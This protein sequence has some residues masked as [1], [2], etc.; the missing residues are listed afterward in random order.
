MIA[1]DVR[2]KFLD[3]F[4]KNNHPIIPSSPLVPYG[5]P[6]LL[7]TSAG[8]VQFKPYYLGLKD[9]LKRATSCQK[10]FRTTDIDNVGKTIRHLTFFEM[11]GNFSFGDYFKEESLRWGYD[12]L[13]NEIGIDKNRLY[14]SFYK[15][16]IGPKDEEA[17]DIWKKILPKELHTHIFEMGEDNF[18]TMGDIG[19]CGP[20]SEIYYDRGEI[21]HKDCLGPW[22]GCDRYIE[23]WN[24]VFTQFDKQLDGSFKPLPKKNID[25]GMGLERISFIIEDKYSPFETSL[26]FPIIDR[27]IKENHNNFSSDYKKI[28][29][30][31]YSNYDS[32]EKYFT[33]LNDNKAFDIF[34]PTLRIVADHIRASSFLISEG[35]LP[36]NEGRGYILR[37]LIRRAERYVMLLGIK[38]VV[39]YKLVSSVNDIF[40]DIYPQISDNKQHIENV[41]RFEEEGFINTIENAERYINDLIISSKKS[42]LI[43]GSDAFKIYETYGYPY[44]LIKEIAN[45]NGIKVDDDEF[46]N[47]KLK[48]QDISR[49]WKGEE[50]YINIFHRINDRF[51]KTDF[52]GYDSFNSNSRL[53]AIVDEKGNIVN[54]AL[55]GIYWLV[56]DKTPFYAESGGQVSDK[57]LILDKD[58]IVA[59][60]LDVQKPLGDVFYHKVNLRSLIKT[61]LYYDLKID[62][63]RR[64][65]ISANHTATHLINAALKTVFGPNT[66][67]AGSLVSD[68]KFR[69]D[70]NITK[71]PTLEELKRVEEI[72]NNAILSG[73]RV[74]KETRP[75]SD[76]KKLGAVV[77]AG[78]RYS[79]P[80]RFVLINR[81]GFSNPLD[82]YSL[83]L[84]GGTHVDDLKD[85]FMLKIL[86]DSSLSRGIRRIEGVSGYSLIDYLYSRENILN[87][88]LIKLDANDN[89]VVDKILK[90][91]DEIRRLKNSMLDIKKTNDDI[92]KIKDDYNIVFIKI[93]AGDIKLIRNISDRKINEYKKSFI[94]VYSM[95]KNKINFVFCK[96]KDNEMSVKK[97]YDKIKDKIK[98]KGGGRDDFIQGGGHIDDENKLKDILLQ[99]LK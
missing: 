65:K 6:T 31:L 7:F 9:D 30:L 94:F 76:A 55:N 59:E 8:M 42:G 75:L 45:K 95:E 92:L 49:K 80:A 81:D 97:V 68:E 13:I 46:E 51:P 43:S 2:K 37:R 57:G 29:D 16:G 62:L 20:S 28:A 47:A 87:D 3:F 40:S 35:V 24:H 67:Q 96:T 41:I 54:E 63:I 10:C 85:V 25:T 5:D 71:T 48:A 18:W 38:D 44:E 19:P 53:V 4:A 36:S 21:F 78:E 70:Y 84:C 98:L 52:I 61:S 11:L 17:Y 33:A 79:D 89:D 74:F 90:L 12:F 93:D 23:I 27:F 39:L 14:F 99:I 32:I 50:E 82:R 77:L 15:G 56:F 34:I 26:F 60:V 66:L 64:R 1:N 91:K 58:D 22:C 83:E 86:K 72:C 69:F 73:L 88:I